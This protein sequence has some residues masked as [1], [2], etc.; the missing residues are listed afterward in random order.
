MRSRTRILALLVACAP[1]VSACGDDAGLLA[2]TVLRPAA[3]A[4]Y[5]DT[6]V[7]IV[8]DSARVGVPFIVQ[9]RSFGD[10]CTVQDQ[11][12]IAVAGRRVDVRPLVREPGPAADQACPAVLLT[13]THSAP[14]TLTEAGTATIVV[15]GRSEPGAS[16]VSVMRTVHVVP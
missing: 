5:G 4:F 10:G 15:H 16:S 1:L 7:A 2:V 13:F 12:G 8:P 11:T 6:I 9:V 3:I 14:I